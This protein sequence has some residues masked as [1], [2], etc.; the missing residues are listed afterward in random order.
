MVDGTRY[1][2]NCPQM[3]KVL[4]FKYDIQWDGLTISISTAN[5]CSFFRLPISYFFLESLAMLFDLKEFLF[6]NLLCTVVEMANVAS[7]KF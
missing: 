2:T 6:A 7:N 1:L 5:I 3:V 4:T